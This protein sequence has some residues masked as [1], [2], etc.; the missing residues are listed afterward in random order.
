MVDGNCFNVGFIG[1]DV[2]RPQPVGK[3]FSPSLETLA[4]SNSDE[5][6]HPRRR[7]TILAG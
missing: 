1:G 7:L 6:Q 2:T 5:L 3:E 4:H